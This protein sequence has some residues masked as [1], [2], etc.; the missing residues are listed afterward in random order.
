MIKKLHIVA[1]NIPYPPDYGGVIDIFYR[2]KALH[3]IGVEIILHCFKYNRPESTELNKYCTRVFYYER[4]MGI[5]NFL[6]RLPF[7]VVSRNHPL[8]LENILREPAPVLFDGIHCCYFLSHEKLEDFPKIVRTHN[9]EHH[10]YRALMGST[11]SPFKRFYFQQEARKLQRFEKEL[12]HANALACISPGDTSYFSKQFN[13]TYFVPAFHPF[14]E[15]VSIPGKGSYILFH[16]NLSVPENEK[17]LDFILNEVL[18]HSDHPLIVAGKDPS[19][20]IRKKIAA[21]S[22]WQLIENP[23]DEE[24]NDLIRQAQICL[25]PTFQSTGLKLK[26]LA[27]LFAGKFVVANPEM[28]YGSGV[29]ELVLVGKSAKD[30]LEIV[31]RAMESEFTS[32]EIEK[33]KSI[34]SKGFSNKNSAQILMGIIANQ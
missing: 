32:V 2:I 30:L 24:M 19:E 7:I 6:S 20:K 9:V 31:N 3:Q 14:E 4:E 34:L 25:I 10:Y 1:L 13:N 17:A 29:E 33:R 28:V 8:L 16:G 22:I 11:K 15:V 18:P 5:F 12:K 26:L 21:K 27:S 23:S